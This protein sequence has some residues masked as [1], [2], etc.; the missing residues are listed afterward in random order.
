MRDHTVTCVQI[1]EDILNFNFGFIKMKLE[2]KKSPRYK[3]YVMIFIVFYEFLFF[4]G[5]LN[6]SDNNHNHM[7]NN[8]KNNDN[9]T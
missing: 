1:F 4:C 3:I 9:K 5:F 6:V 8:L 7:H 2:L